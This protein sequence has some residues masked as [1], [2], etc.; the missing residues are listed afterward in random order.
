MKQSTLF[1]LLAAVAISAAAV[2]VT[3]LQ[4]ADYF[5]VSPWLVAYPALLPITTTFCCH[6]VDKRLRPWR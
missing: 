2:S 3:L 4:A 1:A 5:S 6:H